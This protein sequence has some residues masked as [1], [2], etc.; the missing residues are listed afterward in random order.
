MHTLIQE[1]NTEA[2][3]DADTKKKEGAELWPRLN[4]IQTRHPGTSTRMGEEDT[5]FLC[6]AGAGANT[7]GDDDLTRGVFRLSSLEMVVT[8]DRSRGV[9][10]W[11]PPWIFKFFFGSCSFRTQE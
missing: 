7:A 6:G 1:L 10:G 2:T 4:S 11:P 8:L 9:R 3:Q 5:D